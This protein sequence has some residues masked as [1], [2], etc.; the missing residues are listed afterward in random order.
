MVL[1]VCGLGVVF[2]HSISAQTVG[3]VWHFPRTAEPIGVL[4][5]RNP[6]YGITPGSNVTF[7]NG[8]FSLDGDGL[9]DNWEAQNG[10]NPLSGSGTNGASGDL[11][12]DGFTNAQ[13]F[14]AGTNPNDPNSLLRIT[15]TASGGRTI[16]WS[17]VTGKTYRVFSAPNLSTSFAPLSGNLPSAGA[18]TSYTDPASAGTQKY[19][20]VQ[21]VP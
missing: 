6:A 15:S 17:S 2:A 14:A 12:H 4:S 7:Y 3:N 21:I 5:M 1:V 18:T 13:E 20:R 16:T 8:S 10:L 9:S 11:D 19:Y